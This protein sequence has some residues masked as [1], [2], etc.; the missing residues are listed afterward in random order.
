M[1]TQA[2]ATKDSTTKKPEIV[3]FEVGTDSAGDLLSRNRIKT[4]AKL[5]VGLVATSYFEFYRMYEGLF[6]Q[7]NADAEVVFKRL[8]PNHDIVRTPLVDTLDSADEAGRM[9]R[10]QNVDLIIFAYRA[11]VPD[12]YIHHLLSHVPNVP[13]LFFAS[14]SRDK[15]EFEDSY[16]G[17]LR[18]SGIMAQVQLVAGFRKMNIYNEIEAVAGSIYDDTA[19][20]KINRYIEVVTIYKQLK[21]MT[22]GMIGNVFRGMFDFEFDKTK[23]K[24]ALGPEVMNI[25]VDHL[26]AQWEK[27]PMSDPEVQKMLKHAKT[28]YTVDGVG[29]EDLNNAARIAVAI[30]RLVDRF[31][32]DGLVVLCQHFLEAKLKSTP[33][34]GLSEL[35]RQGDCPAT[36]EGDVLGLVMMKILKALTGNM[37]FFVEWSEFDVEHNAW[38]MLGHGFGDPSQANH[39]KARLTPAAEQW[40]LEGT[41][42]SACFAPEPGRCTMAHFIEDAKGWRMVITGGEILDLPTMP[43]NDT[44]VIVKMDRPIREYTEDLIKAGV[45][46]HAMTVRGECREELKQLAKLMKMETTIL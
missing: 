2:P 17:V 35:H 5:K 6:E 15:F 14:Q 26:L 12:A 41:G 42:C 31:Q 18:N 1:I 13:V 22:F 28:A 25:Q 16:R 36:S 43:I 7:I 32:L 3:S 4:K 27:A 38:M 24:G 37:A 44:H 46:H 9:M 39:G 8:K 21:T 40:G 29:E 20:H 10:E 11:Y 30:R 45:P 23:V 19:Y 33:Y 34:L